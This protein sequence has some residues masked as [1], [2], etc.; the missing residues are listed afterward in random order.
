MSWPDAKTALA[1][2]LATV[3]ITSPFAQTIA[4]VHEDPPG[5]IVDLP[6]IVIYPPALNVRRQNSI[7]YKDYRVR[8]RLL[9]SDVDLSRA[10]ALIDSYREALVD[11]FDAELTLGGNATNIE[12]P[13]IEEGSAFTIGGKTFTGFD[14]FLTVHLREGK[15]FSG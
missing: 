5:S 7:R 15:S 13:E 10:A 14:A 12:G 8:L 3:E 1:A 6:C 11:V 4:K 2:D 9:V